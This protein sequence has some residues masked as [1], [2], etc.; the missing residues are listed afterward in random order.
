MTK[1]TESQEKQLKSKIRKLIQESIFEDTDSIN[2]EDRDPNDNRKNSK[3]SKAKE[4]NVIKWL[5]SEQENN[6]AVARELWPE[7]DDDAARSLFS[8]KLRGHDSE[9]K[10][11]S[12][13]EDEV[14]TLYNIKDRFITKIDESRLAQI[15]SESVKKVLGSK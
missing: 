2:Y 5:K 14:N 9:G 1:L 7:L 12:F 8:K 6:A 3:G 4:K 11:Y 10:P 13:S 15:I